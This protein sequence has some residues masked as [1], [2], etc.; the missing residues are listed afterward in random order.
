MTVMF[1][2]GKRHLWGGPKTFLENFER[3]LGY[4]IKE[5]SSLTDLKVDRNSPLLI[6]NGNSRI[7]IQIYVY[8]FTKR[9]IIMRVGA[10]IDNDQASSGS[11]RNQ[12][13]LLVRKM[14]IIINI[15]F[16]HK[17]IFQSQYSLNRHRQ[18]QL[19]N[20]L[21]NVRRHVVI[22][23]PC[24]PRD[25]DLTRH[26]SD[27]LLS[28]EGA[29]GRET[30]NALLTALSEVCRIVAVGSHKGKVVDKVNYTG[31]IPRSQVLDLHS[32][33]PLAFLCLEQNANCP[34]SVI[35]ALSHGTPV[36]GLDNGSLRELVEGGGIFLAEM[37]DRQTIDKVLT[38]LKEDYWELSK[39]AI[40]ASKKFEANRIF[41]AYVSF[42][43]D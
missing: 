23:N 28:V 12:F 15:M 21:I 18:H 31:K 14:L 19:L 11:P 42:I 6:I 30:H 39:K 32:S 8:L 33:R 17:L 22:L 29:F 5:A 43:H 9:T 20:R 41:D 34:N 24:Y 3:Y 16:S 13:L 38:E 37:P 40:Q 35:E 2:I 7:F 10:L 36:V 1:R 27:F 4:E 26:P 25:V